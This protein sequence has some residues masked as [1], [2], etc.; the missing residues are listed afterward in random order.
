MSC[1]WMALS[2]AVCTQ[3]RKTYILKQL[4][5]SARRV[6]IW[7]SIKILIWSLYI[8]TV[9][10]TYPLNSDKITSSL[11]TQ[12]N[13][14]T[15]VHTPV[16]VEC[17][18]F[19]LLYVRKVKYNLS[20]QT[21]MHSACEGAAWVHVC[22]RSHTH[23]VEFTVKHSHSPSPHF[24]QSLVCS[25]PPTNN[26]LSHVAVADAEGSNL[27]SSA[28]LLHSLFTLASPTSLLV[29][30][31]SASIRFHFSPISSHYKFIV[32]RRGWLKWCADSSELPAWWRVL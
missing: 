8:S 4:S 6:I 9:T 17:C 19:V 5:I 20:V 32:C 29:L 13:K 25:R 10:C 14:D 31:L 2:Q 3:A 18:R 12:A 23:T 16:H 28:S 7:Q 22:N 11:C 27:L 15:Y 24:Q 26:T 30:F 1:G 21:T